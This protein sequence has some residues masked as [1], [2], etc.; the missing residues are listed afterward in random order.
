LVTGD[1]SRAAE[2][3]APMNLHTAW[4][5]ATAWCTE[6]PSARPPPGIRV[7]CTD[8]TGAGST[9]VGSSGTSA[10]NPGMS[11]AS[12]L[13]SRRTSM[14]S[15]PAS[16]S[17]STKATPGSSTQ[18]TTTSPVP[19]TYASFPASGRYTASVAAREL[20]R[21]VTAAVNSPSPPGSS[22]RN[23]RWMGG[24]TTQ[25]VSKK[26]SLTTTGS[27]AAGAGAGATRD[28]ASTRTVA[29]AGVPV[30]LAS[31]IG[32]A[33]DL[34]SLASSRRGEGERAVGSWSTLRRIE[35][36][37]SSRPPAGVFEEDKEDK[38][39]CAVC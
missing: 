17:A 36:V 5:S 14:V 28:T 22:Y 38:F 7:A 6:R 24:S 35:V 2:A 29:V 1:P 11:C 13:A 33:V 34:L 30:A 32:V 18:S 9:L 19:A 27:A 8:R 4:P 25:G 26:D 21:R 3:Q 20:L 39:K 16:A 10:R 37:E 31:P 12:S 15:I 23:T